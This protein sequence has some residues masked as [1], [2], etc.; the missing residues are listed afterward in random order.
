LICGSMPCN[1]VFSLSKW[2]LFALCLGS[3]RP[4]GLLVS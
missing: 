1:F 4:A 2:P 3:C